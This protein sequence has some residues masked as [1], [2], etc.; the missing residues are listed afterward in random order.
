MSAPLWSLTAF[1]FSVPCLN[2]GTTSGSVH[3]WARRLSHTQAALQAGICLCQG[4]SGNLFLSAQGGGGN[5]MRLYNLQLHGAFHPK[6]LLTS[7]STD[8]KGIVHP[9][10]RGI[11]HWK[12]A[13]FKRSSAAFPNRQGPRIGKKGLLC[14]IGPE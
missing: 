2:I 10:L 4:S 1:T 9:P 12:A 5:Q 7:E 3:S 6:G 8:C 13:S 14:W 11:Q